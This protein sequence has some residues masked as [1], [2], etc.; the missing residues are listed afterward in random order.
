L[1]LRGDIWQLDYTFDGRRRFLSL[2]TRDERVARKLKARIYGYLLDNL[3][4]EREMDAL[5][6]RSTT[7]L[8]TIW[9]LFMRQYAADKSAKTVQSYEG[10][11]MNIRRYEALSACPLHLINYPLVQGY[12]EARKEEV[13]NR[14]VNIEL[15]HLLLLLDHAVK[16]QYLERNPL[17]GIKIKLKEARKRDV[18]LSEDDAR[19]LLESLPGHLADIMTVLL[20]SGLRKEE[21]LSLTADEITF[22]DLYP[23]AIVNK[24]VKGG[25]RKAI[26][27]LPE[28][29]EV[30]RRR[31]G[32]GYVFKSRT[33]TRFVSIH[34][35]FNR[36]VRKLGLT[37]C[38]GSKLRIHD[39][40][41]YLASMLRA[42][43]YS[44]EDIQAVLGHDHRS[45]TE[46]YITRDNA[47]LIERLARRVG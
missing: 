32:E 20:F 46:R 2:R 9:P 17:R 28:A 12:I 11:M 35:G 19:R 45:S 5:E 15:G 33:G 18:A 34:K 47:A 39:L 41:H 38:D 8:E 26:L 29:T 21:V 31:A 13:S 37:A 3:D 30:L 27:C 4:P 42:D 36:H 40:R 24:V 23:M 25:H 14:T 43:D 44:L 16:M 7:T 22:C 1:F 6:K 10:S